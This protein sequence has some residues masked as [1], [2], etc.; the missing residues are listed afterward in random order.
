MYQ[1][2]RHC[3]VQTEKSKRP[4]ENKS[5][6]LAGDKAHRGRPATLTSHSHFVFYTDSDNFATFVRWGGLGINY[7]RW[8]YP[9]CQEPPLTMSGMWYL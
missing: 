7:E 4:P 3:R 5:E 6:W 1:L 2:G 9:C 8:S